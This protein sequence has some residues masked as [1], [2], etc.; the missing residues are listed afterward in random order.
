MLKLVPRKEAS[1]PM[2]YLTP[3]LAVLLT[4]AAGFVLFGILGKDP[5]RAM[6]LIFVKPLTS[7]ASLAELLVK[8]TPL[9]LIAI[10]LAVGFRANVWNIGAEG[11][12]TVGAIGG[13][14]V[15]LAFYPEGGI[16]LLPLMCLGG[17]AGGMAWAAIAA[18]LKTRFN[19]NEI[20][21]SLMLTYVAVLLL[22]YLTHG[23]LRD[24]EGQNFPESR[25]FQASALLPVIMPGTRAHI[26]SIVALGV[27][28]AAFV[29]IERSLFGFKVKVIGAAPKAARFAGFKGDALVWLCFMISGGLAGLAGLF[30]AAGPVGQLVPS[31]PVGYGFTA[32]I[33]AFLGRLHPLGILLA[34]LVMA[35]TY[36]GGETAQIEM[37]LP[38]ATTSVFQGLLLFFLLATDVLVNFRLVRTR[39]PAPQVA[40]AAVQVVPNPGK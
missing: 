30:E 11:Q 16:W 24:P 35:L 36:I 2:L 8:G 15:A 10:G 40:L 4:I 22:S 31:L 33:V 17:I 34:G 3:F 37:S 39:H 29:I 5:G 20:L 23:P 32:I 6:W 1:Q 19:A 7:Y 14:G 28:V 38:S 26:G 12:F 9:V 21:V 27:A 25:L 13:G 18:V